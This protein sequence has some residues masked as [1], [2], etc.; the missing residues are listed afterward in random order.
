MITALTWI[1]AN[2]GT[3]A[4]IAAAALS[5]AS[6]VAEALGHTKTSKVLGTVTFDGGRITRYAK[7]CLEAHRALKGK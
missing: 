6:A 5:L 2:P 4:G 7:L 3:V 1:L